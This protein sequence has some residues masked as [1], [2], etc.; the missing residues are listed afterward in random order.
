VSNFCG[1]GRRKRDLLT[2]LKLR[3]EITPID[4]VVPTGDGEGAADQPSAL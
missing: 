3:H 1:S 4:A 2:L